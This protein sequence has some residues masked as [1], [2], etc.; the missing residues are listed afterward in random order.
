MA[1]GVRSQ[2]MTVILLDI[3]YRYC[4]RTLDWAGPDAADE[5]APFKSAPCKTSLRKTER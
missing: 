1:P 5:P 3:N 2:N 4:Y